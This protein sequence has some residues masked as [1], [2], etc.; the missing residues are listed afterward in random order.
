MRSK[1]RFSLHA[2][3]GSWSAMKPKNIPSPIKVNAVGKPIMITTTMSASMVR[4]SAGSLT[5]RSPWSDAL[6]SG[7]V[8]LVHAL[9][10]SLA[11]FLVYVLAVRELLFHHVDLLRVL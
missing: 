3:P 8:D 1:T 6:V 7:L 2:W 5:F 11:R 4:P 10:R 9:E